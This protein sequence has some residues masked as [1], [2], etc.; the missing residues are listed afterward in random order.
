MEPA[1]C[2][3]LRNEPSGDRPG[4]LFYAVRA[5]SKAPCYISNNVTRKI[6]T[7]QALQARFVASDWFQLNGMR[8][9]IDSLR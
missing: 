2:R 7:E 3:Q 9:R 6:R 8:S 5:A 4:G 1:A